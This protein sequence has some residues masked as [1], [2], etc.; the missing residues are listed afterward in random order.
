MDIYKYLKK[1]PSADPNIN[2]KIFETH[3]SSA[4]NNVM[5]NKKNKYNKYKH[6]KTEWITDGILKSIKY[7][8]KLYKSLKILSPGSHNYYTLKS[9]LHVYK[10]IL[11]KCIRQAK[12]HIIPLK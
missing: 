1:D 4:I 12:K 6:K 7:K 2:Y 3:I 9:N 10:T 8:D 5:P 11:S